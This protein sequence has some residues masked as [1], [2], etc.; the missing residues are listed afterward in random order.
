MKRTNTL[1]IPSVLFVG[2]LFQT[3]IIASDLPTITESPFIKI[4]NG[5]SADYIAE[6]QKEMKRHNIPMAVNPTFTCL[7][8]GFD[9]K[10]LFAEGTMYATKRPDGSLDIS[11]VGAF[12]AYTYKRY[13]K[14]NRECR[15]KTYTEQY[16]PDRFGEQSYALIMKP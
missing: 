16:D 3:G 11:G 14:G 12:K 9:K 10:D 13:I 15:E 4:E 5:V 6:T 2:L 8:A 1:T 7:D